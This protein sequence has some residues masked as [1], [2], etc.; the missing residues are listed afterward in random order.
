MC[1]LL[2]FSLWDFVP[3]AMFVLRKLWWQ[4]PVKQFVH[5]SLSLLMS[6]SLHYY[7]E[8]TYL[9]FLCLLKP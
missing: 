5:S 7:I 1:L 9:Q 8:S 4:R 3:L 2:V 6:I